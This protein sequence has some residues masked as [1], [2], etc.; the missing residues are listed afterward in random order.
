MTVAAAVAAAALHAVS[1]ARSARL[2]ADL[3]AAFHAVFTAGWTLAAAV[4]ALQA[5]AGDVPRLRPVAWPGAAAAVVD[6]VARVVAAAVSP[7][8]GGP[9]LDIVLATL[10]AVI[11]VPLAVIQ[12]TRSCDT[13]ADVACKRALL[14][15]PAPPSG[16]DVEAGGP[17]APRRPRRGYAALLATAA[18][19]IWPADAVGQ[20][21]ATTCVVLIVLSRAVNIAVPASYRLLVNALADADARSHPPPGAGP[22][23]PTPLATLMVPAVVVYLAVFYLQGGAGGGMGLL[24]NARSFLWVPVSQAAA[25][26]ISLDAFSHVLDLD[27]RFHLMRK[28]GEL[29]RTLDRGTSAVQTLLSTTVFQVGPQL[30]DIV[31]ASIY[32]ATALRPSVAA[33]MFV[34]LASYIPITIVLTEW[35]GKHRKEMIAADN[36]KSSRMTDALLNYETVRNGIGERE[37]ER[38]KEKGCGQ[39][40]PSVF[41]TN[42]PSN[43][44]PLPTQI[45]YYT[46]ENY[47]RNRYRDAIAAYQAVEYRLMASL[48]GLNVIQSTIIFAGTAAGLYVCA[49]GVAAGDL[50]VGD[51]VLYLSLVAQ[52]AVPLN[53]FGTFYRTIQQQMLDVDSM[54]ALLSNVA[55]VADEPDAGP[56]RLTEGRVT[57]RNVVYAW[58]PELPPVLRNVSIDV[59]GGTSL[60]VVGPT[61]SGKS[62]LLRL[63]FRFADPA[64]GTVLVDGQDVRRVTQQSLRR[65][66]AVVPQD[67]VL[68]NDTIR[69]NLAF[70]RPGASQADIEAAAE[71]ASMHAAILAMP[72]GYDTIVGERGLRLSGGEKQRVA[73]ARAILKK[74]PILM[75]DEATSALDTGTEAI[76]QGYLRQGDVD[77]RPRTTLIVAHRLSTVADCDATVVMRG[78]EVVER[79]THASLVA[80]GGLYADLWSRQAFRHHV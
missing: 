36:A 5:R 43:P 73:L 3:V 25:A 19:F 7:S 27:L 8:A 53:W 51:A 26:S 79:G 47:E 54:F 14:A 52:L 58:G 66:M 34:T 10:R 32:V 62:T 37:R 76:V 70:A 20:I 22:P 74:A 65:A 59:P 44:S 75:L 39:P 28:T 71:A 2:G 60:A 31:A 40:P 1:A 17:S 67:S 80:A 49:V 13:A 35:R 38:R 11:T 41:P 57:F 48:A 72:A 64:S 68:F 23:V 30:V 21:R 4:A 77:G 24:N 63:A 45:K 6:A 56:L 42:P 16:A 69:A 46:A 55:T 33:I 61:G 12:A 29:T 18:A 15:G 50:R 9:P 78:G